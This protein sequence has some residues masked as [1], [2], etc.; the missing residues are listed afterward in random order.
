[1]LL[2]NLFYYE[3]KI[4][5]FGSKIFKLDILS[6]NSA[7]GGGLTTFFK[8]PILFFLLKE[9]LYGA[10]LVKSFDAIKLFNFE[11]A[12]ISDLTN[13]EKMARNLKTCNI[14]TIGIVACTE[15]PWTVSYPIPVHA[16][17]LFSQYYFIRYLYYIQQN[18]SYSRYKKLLK[19]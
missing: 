19:L 1:M 18:A 9:S 12:F 4:I 2:Y 13:N 7:S 10:N 11:T 14:Y 8:Y 5:L 3:H 16:N 15:D 17:G 6:L